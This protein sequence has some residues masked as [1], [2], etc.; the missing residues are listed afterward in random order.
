MQKAGYRQKLIQIIL[1]YSQSYISKICAKDSKY[2]PTIDHITDEQRV[3]KYVVD[4]ILECRAITLNDSMFN[5]DDIAYIKL[6]DYCLVDREKIR[7]IYYNVS[8]YKVSRAFRNS[9]I[10]LTQFQPQ[11]IG[12]TE[13]EFTIFL[14]NVF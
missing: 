1:G 7:A 10:S 8:P 9:K 11:L 14:E 6:L 13:E 12:I 3:R 4:R 2:V 5:D